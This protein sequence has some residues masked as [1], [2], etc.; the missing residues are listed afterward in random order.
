VRNIYDEGLF[1]LGVVRQH[2][3]RPGWRLTTHPG[4]L[5][6]T[7][8]SQI[9]DPARVSEFERFVSTCGPGMVFFDVGARFGLFCLAALHYAPSAFCVAVEP[10]LFAAR[11][12]RLHGTMNYPHGRL[13]IRR[14]AAGRMVVGDPIRSVTVDALS[15]EYGLTPTHLKIDVEGDEAS[16]LAGAADCLKGVRGRR[17]LVFLELHND[18]ISSRGG[19]PADVLNTLVS[20]GYRL[21]TVRGERLSVEGAVWPTLTR[22]VAVPR[23]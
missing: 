20:F 2:E 7:F 3:I 13:L 8:G 9:R 11:M 14:A 6:T 17:P 23:D 21:E 22:L 18:V 5:R 10:S 16:V 1:C 19:K 4:A 15:S 12:L